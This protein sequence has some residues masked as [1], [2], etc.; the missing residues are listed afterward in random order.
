MSESTGGLEIALAVRKVWN[1]VTAWF[2][3]KALSE[4]AVLLIFAVVT[5]LLSAL[6]VALFYKSIDFAYWAFYKFPIAQFPRFALLTYR[7]VITA[8]GFAVAWWVMRHIGRG[9]EGMNVPDVQLAVVRHG[10]DIE[11]R[12]ALARTAASAITIGAGGS[13]GNEGPVVVLGAAIGSWLGRTFRF[14]PSR[15]VVLIGCATGAAIS[16]AFNAPL[17]GAFFALE[18]VVGTLAAGSFAPVV[19]SSVVAAVVSRAV[20]GNHPAF[21]IPQ[22]YGYAHA[23]EL[24]L[25][26]PI[27]GIVCG[28]IS[29]LYV[30]SYF[31]TGDIEKKINIPDALIPWIGGAVVGLLVFTSGGLLVGYGHLAINADIFGRMAWYGLLALALGKIIATAVTLNMGGSG[32]VFTPSLYIGAATGG[33][34][35]VALAAAFP[36]M[37]LHPEAY[38]LVGM[39]A[40]VA[41]ATDA[42]ITGIL[43]IFEMTND[44]AI[45]IPLMLTVVICHTIARRLSPDSLYSGWL[46]RRGQS[47][48]KGAD[49][50]ILAG[51][52]V[53]DAYES[54]PQVIVETA[55]ID[56]LVAHLDQ[57]TQLYFPVVD[58]SHVL[59]GVITVAELG[60]LQ[61][62]EEHLGLL[63]LAGD[64][65]QQSE[66]VSPGDSLLEAIRKMGVRGA[67]SIPVVDRHTH[68]LLGL[69][70]R[71]HVLNLYERKV[72][73]AGRRMHQP[74]S[75]ANASDGGMSPK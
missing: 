66:S 8:T 27:L 69:I 50:D 4:N 47:I 19:V 29:A 22:Q 65:A 5:G 18:E 26:Y 38:A 40:V 52:H 41:G 39:G 24:L 49:Q 13:A 14:A 45:V 53:S 11:G 33:A 42:P 10:G 36:A 61:R 60:Q 23:S 6:G 51:L 71:S 20:F 63:L 37:G 46:R 48:E 34:F 54:A 25:L 55:T 2:N 57:T 56:E 3:G 72:S 62:N 15:V 28:L 74:A 17:A 58:E 43:L 44:Y 35:G 7:P 31:A 32:G 1:G 21:A 16:A 75:S 64:I 67:E 68:R 73:A 9:H 59:I 30:R 12:P 70:D